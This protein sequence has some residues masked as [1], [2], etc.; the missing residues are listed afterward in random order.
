MSTEKM[1]ILATRNKMRFPYKGMVSV[2]DL[3]DMSVSALDSVFKNLNSQKKQAEEESLLNTKSNADEELEL[4]IEIVKYIVSV[5]LSEKE[6]REKANIMR[7]QKQK[8]M[9]I[10]ATKQDEALQNASFDDLQ[11]MLDELGE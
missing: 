7:E 6:T 5:K 8:I 10:M 1:F 9:Q 2:E 4:Q 3:W 11:K